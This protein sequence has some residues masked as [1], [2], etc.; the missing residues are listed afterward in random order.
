[1]RNKSL[2]PI[3][4]EIRKNVYE[5]EKKN[6]L[7]SKTKEMEKNL[8]ELE[9][10]LSRLKKHYDYDDVEY[11]GIR[12]VGDLFNQ[13]IDEE[14]YKP[15]KKPRVLLMV[16]ILNMKLKAMKTKIYQLKKTFV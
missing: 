3:I 8:F 9:E 15:I 2:K 11:K 5:I 6:L 16:I 1:M 7:E 12:D 13:S 4:K 10:S 14:Y